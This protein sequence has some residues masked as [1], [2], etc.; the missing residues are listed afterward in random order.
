MKILSCHHGRNSRRFLQ[1]LIEDRRSWEVLK[2]TRK[3]ETEE[4]SVEV[5]INSKKDIQCPVC[6]I[7]AKRYDFRIRRWRHL[8][9]Y[10]YHTLIEAKVPGVKCTELSNK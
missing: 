2:I 5:G 3:D 7:K 9:L 8:N 10:E 4:V 1:I 6:G